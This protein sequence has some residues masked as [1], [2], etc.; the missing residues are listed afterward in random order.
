MSSRNE[1]L[2][3]GCGGA[4]GRLVDSICDYN[5]TFQQFYINTSRTDIFNLN[6]VDEKIENYLIATSTTNGVGRD[7]SLGKAL[8]KQ[9]GLNMIDALEN[10]PQKTLYLTTS[11]GGGSGS[12]IVTVILEGIQQLQEEGEFNK[13]I[14]LILILPSLKSPKKILENARE[15]WNEI[16]SNPCIN[17]VIFVDN[18][19]KIN[20]TMDEDDKELL[21]NQDFCQIFDSIFDIPEE[22]D[23]VH[24]D[25]RNLRN[26][27]NDKGTLYFYNL[28][29]DCSSIEIAFEKA[30]KESVVAPMFF[31][32]M[33][34]KMDAEG[35]IYY[36]CGYLGIS[37]ANEKYNKDFILNK[38]KPR[39]ETYIGT[40]TENNLLL[41]SG[42]LPPF[43]AITLI[44]KEIEDRDKEEDNNKIDFSAFV[45][46]NNIKNEKEVAISEEPKHMQKSITKK[47]KLRKGLFK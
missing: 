10:S 36:S 9:Y 47:K 38:F 33:N 28:D 19:S 8:A 41:I 46:G 43:D 29:N 34:M 44:N 25:T 1:I 27:L 39:N 5:P 2:L 32:D 26:A 31:N 24:F 13:I 20:Y 40:N 16:I 37:F 23:G 3:V 42:M 45:I 35:N 18:N 4:G 11:L 17:S 22:D 21:V 15:S 14:N 30:K 12:S 6:N 7:K